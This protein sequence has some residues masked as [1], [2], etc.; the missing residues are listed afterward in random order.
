M[1]LIQQTYLIK[2]FIS[3]IIFYMITIKQ[4]YEKILSEQVKFLYPDSQVLVYGRVINGLG[5]IS[6]TRKLVDFLI[7]N[8]IFR[9][10]HVWVA[11]NQPDLDQTI[12]F[13]G[14]GFHIIKSE[15]ERAEKIKNCALQILFI[16]GGSDLDFLKE[17][18]PTLIVREYGFEAFD[19]ALS[20]R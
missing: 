20:R 19:V 14:R 17:G 2:I 6:L 10:D 11:S 5:D 4:A 15:E 18:V 7:A 8:K 12:F 3:F 13:K 1:S 16:E 9:K